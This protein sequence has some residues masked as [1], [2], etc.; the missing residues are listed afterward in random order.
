M[1]RRK[2]AD[3]EAIR[4]RNL[5]AL[6]SGNIMRRLAA[7]SE[8]MM[9]LFSRLRSREP[10]LS[11]IASRFPSATFHDLV[12]LPVHEQAVVNTF[13]ECLDEMRW[14]FTY[15]EDMPLTARQ[16][17]EGLVRRLEE[18]HRQLI[19]V[20]GPAA[21]ADQT[22]VVEGQ[23]IEVSTPALAKAAPRRRRSG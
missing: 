21:R 12:C 10:L 6:D 2:K 11:T 17:A 8:E 7:R 4:V 13:Y 3:E 23:V 20:I 16:V 15:T 5:I 1:P 22:V 19:V 18:A 9:N 14:Y